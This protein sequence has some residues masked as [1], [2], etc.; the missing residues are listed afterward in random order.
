MDSRPPGK[1]IIEFEILGEPASKANSRRAVLI[2]GRPRFIKSAK[3]LEYSKSFLEQCPTL[4]S[5]VKG[6]VFLD[7]TIHYASMRPDLDESLI[8]DLLQGRI[9]ENDRQ[10]WERNVRRRIDRTRPR[11]RIYVEA[12]ESV[13]GEDVS[14]HPRPKSKDKKGG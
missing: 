14:G 2:G 3:A 8:L 10:V 11:T 12:M 6:P 7:I 9:Y 13:P 4:D 1:P 5:L